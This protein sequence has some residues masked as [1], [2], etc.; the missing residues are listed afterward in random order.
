MRQ[1]ILSFSLKYWKEILLVLLLI[2]SVLKY[3]YDMMIM[4]Q[5]H[6]AA[7]ES[8]VQQIETL[9]Q[10]HSD[11]IEQ[12]EEA[13]KQYKER[14]EKIEIEY[15]SAKEEIKRITEEERQTFIEDFSQDKDSLADAI[16]QRYGF[17]Y[18]P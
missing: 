4:R 10:I 14:I 17:T 18:V 7:E 13:L 6:K 15:N 3:Q 16:T 12:R 1:E 9:K 11:E 8:L 2:S 5:T